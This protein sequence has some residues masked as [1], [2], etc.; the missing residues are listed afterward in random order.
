MHQLIHQSKQSFI[1]PLRYNGLKK[2]LESIQEDYAALVKSEMKTFQDEENEFQ[3]NAMVSS[4]F[5]FSLPVLF[6]LYKHWVFL[7]WGKTMINLGHNFIPPTIC[8]I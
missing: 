7:D 5:T 4:K 8:Q 1:Y 2:Q 3:K 6:C